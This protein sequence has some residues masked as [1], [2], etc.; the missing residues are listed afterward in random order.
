MSAR[1]KMPYDID[2]QIEKQQTNAKK[3]VELRKKPTVSLEWEK[4]KEMFNL[5]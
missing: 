5:E 3:P 4:A 2:E 1:D